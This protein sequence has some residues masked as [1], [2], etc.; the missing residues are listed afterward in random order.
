M[1]LLHCCYRQFF[2]DTASLQSPFYVLQDWGR[3]F[4]KLICVRKN[5]YKP[6]GTIRNEQYMNPISVW[7]TRHSTK[8]N[9]ANSFTMQLIIY[10][11]GRI[12]NTW[13]MYTCM[14]GSVLLICLVFCV[15]VVALV[16]FVLCAWC[17]RFLW[18]INFRTPLW[19]S[20]TFIYSIS[21]F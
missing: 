2:E 7:H 6:E 3:S 10:D 4:N 8:T 13:Y 1:N 14:V 18:I 9:K 16:V 20:Q 19:F 11:N 17:C 5:V 21:K 15:V 12:N